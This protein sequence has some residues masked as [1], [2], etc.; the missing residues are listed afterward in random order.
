MK[1]VRIR[2]YSGPYSV[3]WRKMR[4]RITPNMETFCAVG[5]ATK[6]YHMGENCLCIHLLRKKRLFERKLQTVLPQYFE[7]L[8][9]LKGRQ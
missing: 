8:G 4:T 9:V 6:I 2:S 5:S 7:T 1:S 3:R